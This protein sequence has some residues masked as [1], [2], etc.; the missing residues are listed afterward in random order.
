MKRKLL[1]IFLFFSVL[2]VHSASFA[3]MENI[4]ITRITDYAY[5]GAA[6]TPSP[7]LRDG[8]KALK[9]DVDY[10]LECKNNLNVGTATM[11]IKGIGNY[12]GEITKEF[13]I[14]KVRIVITIDG[15]QTK[16]YGKPD[17]KLTYK[18]TTGELK[19]ADVLKGTLE[20]LPGEDVGVYAISQG[21]L[22]AG[23]NYDL[24]VV[25]NNFKI[26][27][28]IITIKPAP[29]Q[30]KI[31]GQKDPEIKYTIAE[32]ALVGKDV[33]TGTL[34]HA[35]GENVGTYAITLGSLSAGRN[36]E[37]RFLSDVSF[38]ILKADIAI[39]PDPNQSKTYGAPDPALTYTIVSGSL[40]NCDTFKGA[41]SRQT[42]ED[43][44][45]YSIQQ[46]SLS[47]SNNYN[48]KVD[49]TEKFEIKRKSF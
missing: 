30:N 31:Y 20:R 33:L 15:G 19:G 14:T 10:T 22:T 4:A 5:T 28:A 11:V 44:G 3:A 27:K 36:Y 43:V 41:L 32:G 26:E 35:M 13:K 40:Y 18:I 8:L 46:G 9:K 12:T 24:M 25:K 47:L 38:E 39:K 1:F 29:S 2:G 21:T 42:G 34:S 37:L 49:A 17:P 23:D 7:V 45:K 48:L 6:I 16:I